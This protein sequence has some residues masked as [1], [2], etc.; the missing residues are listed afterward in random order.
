VFAW[1]GHSVFTATEGPAPGYWCA[2]PDGGSRQT[3]VYEIDLDA[4]QM[5]FGACLISSG[6]VEGVRV[7]TAEESRA[8]N[9]T[10]NALT[11]SAATSPSVA[12]KTPIQLR[13]TVRL[14]GDAETLTP[15]GAQVYVDHLD[16]VF[17]QLKALAE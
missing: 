12:D 7:F 15:V 9:D 10:L 1:E 6:N 5:T 2:R 11:R 17:D 14:Y 16:A 8:L 13:A 4:G 3:S